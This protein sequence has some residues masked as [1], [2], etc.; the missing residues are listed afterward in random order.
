MPISRPIAGITDCS[1]VLPDAATSIAAYSSRKCR[2]LSAVDP[3]LPFSARA[4]IA[5]A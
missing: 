5:S 3:T 4:G 2:E 1:A